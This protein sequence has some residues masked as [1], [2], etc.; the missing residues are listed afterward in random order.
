MI[1]TSSPTHS[2]LASDVD[3]VVVGAG[4]AGLYM[5]HRLRQLGLKTQVCEAGKGVGGTWYW[6]RYPGAR[7]DVESMQYSYSF[8]EELQQEWQWTE[9]YPKQD[10]ILRYINHVA[11]RFELRSDIAFETRISSAIYD[12]E[13]QRWTVL[14]EHGD[15]M[16]ARFLITAAGC[17]SA[18]RMPDLAGLDSFKGQFYH[19]GNWP[20]EPVDFT[21]KRVG[22]IGTGSS[23]VQTIPVIARQ[24]SE[25]VVFQRTPNFS[26]PAWNCPLSDEDQQS[27]KADYAANR[28]KARHTRSGILY[29]YSTRATTD[30]PEA[31]REAEYERRWQRGGAN[32]TH[33]F[34]DIYTNRSSNDSAAQFVRN[35][36][37]TTV[38]DPDVAA[39]LAPNDHAIGT[40]RI[41][42]DTDYYQTFN[43]PHVSLVDLRTAPI[44]EIVPE[45]MRTA[46]ATY[47]LDCIVF[48]TGYDAVTG[49]LD[50][51]DIRGTGGL[52]LKDKW[53]DGP[54]T[55]LG[56][57]TA[58]FPNL[59]FITGP[60]SPSIL[61][62][63]VVAIEQ[64]VNW[65]ANCLASMQKNE[66][67]VAE[68]DLSAE[69]DWVAHVNEVAS[70]TLF[71]STKSWFMGANI[72]GKPQ[73]FLPY[74]GGF[75]NY[76]VICEEVVADDYRGFAFTPA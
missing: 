48:A 36:I 23:G 44:V 29:E 60:G 19:T 65:I 26:I 7:C 73:V 57:M 71:P 70:K 43:Q 27:W 18:A 31:E 76:S 46:A 62:N 61:T 53:T 24:A 32:Y 2:A 75:G 40:K 14:T 34:N 68:A 28:E 33:A 52:S 20:H 56:L 66:R 50:R 25:L 54:R 74:V 42:V 59:F 39:L 30:V 45:G 49:A 13:S 3:V 38:N 47:D 55:Y 41:C 8:S 69:N 35:K 67:G 6:N 37:H 12:A 5:L 58:G 4:F 16:S 11:D 21:G 22:V 1:R 10:E 9:R 51:I 15:T 72:P 63:V 64:H 17:L